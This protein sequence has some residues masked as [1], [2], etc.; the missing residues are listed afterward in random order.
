MRFFVVK[1][2]DRD[3]FFNADEMIGEYVCD[4]PMLLDKEG[5][6][7]IMKYCDRVHHMDNDEVFYNHHLEV[8]EAQ[9]TIL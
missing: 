3:L 7:S 5:V 1:V 4:T 2:K 8:R 9:L 6:E